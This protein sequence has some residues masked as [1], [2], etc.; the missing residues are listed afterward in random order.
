MDVKSKPEIDTV[1]Q[2]VEAIRS[3]EKTLGDKGRVLVRYSGT[4]SKC[5]VMV[6]GPTQE[7]THAL[8]RQI[9][10]VVRSQLN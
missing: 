1:P 2:I 7:M 3:V 5:R 9:A 8:C 10:E 6:E 4:Q